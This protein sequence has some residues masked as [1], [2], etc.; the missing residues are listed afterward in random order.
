MQ[1]LRV[2]V[3][4]LGIGRRHLQSYAALPEVQTAAIA[5]VVFEA[6]QEQA[7]VYGA[8][9]YADP[10]AMLREQRLDAISLCTPPKS[11]RELTEAAAAVGTH[12]LC[13]KPMAP[14]LADCDAMIA[15]CRA[16]NVR[17]MV[18]QKMRFHPLIRRM[19]AVSEGELGAIRWAVCKYALGRVP[20][21]WFWAEDDGG[22]PLLEN[23]IHTVDMMRFLAGEVQSVYAEGGNL[24]NPERAPQLDVA[25]C[26]LRFENGAVAA[27]GLGQASEWSWADEHFFFACEQGEA[28]LSGRFDRPT[29]WWMARRE[30][31]SH[32]QE[33][34]VPEDDCFDSEIAHFLH[35]VR[36]GE[37]PFVTGEIARGS[38]AVCL[39]VKESARGGKPVSVQ[40]QIRQTRQRLLYLHAGHPNIR[41]N[42]IA[43]ALHEPVPGAV[44][45]LDP[46]APELPYKS[47][48]EAILDG[49]RVIHFPD[50]RA[51]F[52]D[53][54]IDIVGYEFIL[55]KREVYDDRP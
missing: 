22:G 17:L 19:K 7:Q 54:E 50:Q 14:S 53:R 10:F 45:Q 4:G 16:A 13:E 6:A 3:I 1:P 9:A 8:Q 33:E 32:P 34:T 11:H 5:D 42:V 55:E 21:D 35:S 15:A 51:P 38:V 24:F 36:T 46:L 23:A 37:A 52:D 18:A 26:T 48:F 20:K 2:G 49:W 47:V 12:V 25:V 28:R 41:S 29:H 44:T 30:D 31:P 40:G 27:L 43:A 39:A